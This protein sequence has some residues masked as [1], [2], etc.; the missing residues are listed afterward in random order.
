MTDRAV[1]I[2]LMTTSDLTRVEEIERDCIGTPWGRSAFETELANRCACYV[3]A[4][5]GG[6]TVGFA[7]MWVIM[8]EAHITTLGVQTAQRR[9]GIGRMLVLAL[10]CEARARRANHVS[11][12]VR[13]HN[14][15]ARRLY[16]GFKFVEVAVRRGYYKDNNEDA[17]IMWL[18][19]LSGDDGAAML[20]AIGARIDATE[21]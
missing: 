21:C 16:E 11:L 8:D 2:A 13:R 10:L 4:L 14:S 3:I 9:R 20:G 19:G 17:I 18:E 1:R 6:E 12:E 5:A 7:G 15:A